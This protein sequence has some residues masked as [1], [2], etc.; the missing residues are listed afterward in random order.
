MNSKTINNK[1]IVSIIVP[2]RNE[3]KFIA[4]CLDSIIQQ[5]YP[6]NKMEILV[7]DGMSNDKTR[8][9]IKKYIK[10]YSFIKLLDNPKTIKPVALNMGIK[11]ARGKIIIR[12]DAHAIYD[13]NY[14][15]KCIKYLDKYK[16][17]NVGGIRKTLSGKNSI[18]A[19]AIAI[20]ISHI[21]GAGNASYRTG[22]KKIKWVDT[23]F[24]GCYKKEIFEKIGLFNENLIRCQDRE[25]TVRLKK[26]GRKI[27]LAPDIKCYYYS[28]DNFK[29]F[30]RWIYSGA[31]WVFYANKFTK[32]IIVSWRNFIPSLFVCSLFTSL[33]ISI[34]ISP[35]IWIFIIIISI[36]LLFNFYFSIKIALSKKDIRYIPA[37]ILIFTTTHISYGIG[38]ISGLIKFLTH[39]NE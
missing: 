29:K 17:D 27:L 18:I 8:K 39:K 9:I 6:Q 38:A 16:A 31:F 36:Y 20:S 2:C 24:G 7:V 22:S 26:A 25:F 28:R 21:F 12:M 32:E 37:M 14:V 30:I 15:L 35:F 19:N 23:V 10:N 1:I 5:D 3:E 4:K 34:F 11:T 13:K 33:L